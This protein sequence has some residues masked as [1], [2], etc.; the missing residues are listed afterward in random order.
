MWPRI[1]LDSQVIWLQVVSK[2]EFI[3]AGTSLSELNNDLESICKVVSRSSRK[4]IREMLETLLAE[5]YQ[6]VSVTIEL[7]QPSKPHLQNKKKI[8]LTNRT[9]KS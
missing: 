8:V 1:I 7:N 9:R 4:V 5:D 6:V 3:M 2:G